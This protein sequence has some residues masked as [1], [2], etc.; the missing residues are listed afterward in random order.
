M[1]SASAYA[2]GAS[3]MLCHSGAHVDDAS[4]VMLPAFIP[5]GPV[6]L[7][8]GCST[9]WT[10]SRVQ[11]LIP[12]KSDVKIESMTVSQDHLVVFQRIQGLQV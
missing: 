6:V 10:L 7:N 12:H 5:D 2:S 9:G 8:M 3:V 11:V 1:C 4:D